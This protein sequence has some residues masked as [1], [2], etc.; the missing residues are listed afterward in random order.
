MS[1]KETMRSAGAG[2]AT[3][4]LRQVNQVANSPAW[5]QASEGA[6]SPSIVSLA[7][8]LGVKPGSAGVGHSAQVAVENRGSST[9]RNGAAQSSIGH[10]KPVSA[11]DGSSTTGAVSIA[12]VVEERDPSRRTDCQFPRCK[13]EATPRCSLCS[14]RVCDLHAPKHFAT[15]PLEAHEDDRGATKGSTE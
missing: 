9:S 6:V 12:L 5:W 10:S 8:P 15:H 1:A 13:A 2:P 7:L 4:N 3:K 11:G 14:E